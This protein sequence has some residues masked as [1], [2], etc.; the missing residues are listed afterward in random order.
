[1]SD[2][3]KNKDEMAVGSE[4]CCYASENEVLE[5]AETTKICIIQDKRDKPF[6]YIIREEDGKQEFREN[7]TEETFKSLKEK[8]KLSS[9]QM[10]YAWGYEKGC[11]EV[12][13]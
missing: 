8:G 5:I 12:L 2:K 1:M 9:N 13:V 10:H 7:I 3:N 4:P 6:T 11:Y